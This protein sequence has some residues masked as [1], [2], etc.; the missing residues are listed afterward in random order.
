M[1]H[2]QLLQ[3]QYWQK[4]L[5][6]ERHVGVGDEIT[7]VIN[8]DFAIFYFQILH[9]RLILKAGNFKTENVFSKLHNQKLCVQTFQNPYGCG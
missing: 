4:R 1:R 3:E 7:K 6:T 5:L 2:V 9:K 8:F